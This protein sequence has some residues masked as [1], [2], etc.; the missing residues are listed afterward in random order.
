MVLTVASV[1]Q[2][3][4]K[5][6]GDLIRLVSKAVRLVTWIIETL[7]QEMSVYLKGK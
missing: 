6:F 7:K 1:S 4:R 5:L 2:E 3:R